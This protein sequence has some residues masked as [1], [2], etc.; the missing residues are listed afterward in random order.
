MVVDTAVVLDNSEQWAIQC[1]FY[2][3][4]ILV[5]GDFKQQR[6]WFFSGSLVNN[7]D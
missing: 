3:V 1:F 5:D 2:D 4:E 6:W 7:D